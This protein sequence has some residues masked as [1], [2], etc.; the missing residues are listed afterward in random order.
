MEQLF[1]QAG[2][3]YDTAVRKEK[4]GQIQQI[5]AD[6]SPYVFL[7]YQK[8]WA[9]LNKRIQGIIPSA[10][11][12]GWNSDDWYIAARRSDRQVAGSAWH[13]TSFAAGCNRSS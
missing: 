9:G 6:E 13:I 10:L 7:F 4:Y 12:I 5:I 8:A 3:T 11:G 2:A 1:K